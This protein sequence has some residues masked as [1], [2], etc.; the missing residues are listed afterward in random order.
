MCELF[1]RGVTE[2]GLQPRLSDS[3]KLLQPQ[4]GDAFG[5]GEERV[6]VEFV[7]QET[8]DHELFKRGQPCEDVREDKVVDPAT[9]EAAG[10]VPLHY[11][12]FE[13][14]PVLV[15]ADEGFRCGVLEWDVKIHEPEVL[16]EFS[17]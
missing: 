9:A 17:P 16:F 13:L 4:V 12:R 2:E 11:E 5:H 3:G 15:Y 10:R 8:R 1:A 6:V 14:V 7:V